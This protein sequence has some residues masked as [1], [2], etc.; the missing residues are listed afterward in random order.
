MPRL[1]HLTTRCLAALLFAVLAVVAR[2]AEAQQFPT[3]PIRIIVGNPPGGVNDILGRILSSGMGKAL[4]QS[5]VVENKPGAGGMIAS[6]F[7][8][9]QAAADGYT[10]LVTSPGIALFQIFEKELRFDPIKDLN[11]I[12]ALVEGQLVMWTNMQ[13]PFASFTEL[14]AYARAN[15]GKLNFTAPGL[16]SHPA[17]IFE[18]MRQKLGISFVTIPTKGTSES[19]V[20]VTTNESQIG[21]NDIGTATQEA[22]AGRGRALAVTGPRRLPA[23]PN[24]PTFDELGHGELFIPFRLGIAAPAATPAPVVARISAAVTSAMQTQEARDTFAK[25]GLDVLALGPQ[26]TARRVAAEAAF[27]MSIARKAGIVAQ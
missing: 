25:A 2:S 3:K 15:P 18:G 10:L 21:L 24:V 17:I 7:V 20:L 19:R 1:A 11:H 27:F 9:K 8:A 16:Q 12:S 4:G 14:V 6:E 23:F 5:I 13:T 22:Q 26:E